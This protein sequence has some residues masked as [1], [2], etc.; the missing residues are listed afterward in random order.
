VVARTGLGDGLGSGVNT[1][2]WRRLEEV[3]IKRI[4]NNRPIPGIFT[5]F[6][7]RKIRAL[8]ENQRPFSPPRTPRKSKPRLDLTH[9]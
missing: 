5:L 7:S 2:A 9:S 6:L 1:W 3:E 8:K 4:K